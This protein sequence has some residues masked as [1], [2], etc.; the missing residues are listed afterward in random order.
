MQGFAGWMCDAVNMVCV[1]VVSIRTYYALSWCWARP[2]ENLWIKDPF[3]RS[4]CKEKLGGYAGLKKYALH[5][6]DRE[7]EG[8]LAVVEKYNKRI[9]ELVDRI[10]NCA[11]SKPNCA[12]ETHSQLSPREVMVHYMCMACDFH[13]NALK[14]EV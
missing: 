12:G 4:F 11:Q 10:Y 3:I 7:L 6:E 9:P 13:Q 5:T 14:L 2:T 1:R 8:K